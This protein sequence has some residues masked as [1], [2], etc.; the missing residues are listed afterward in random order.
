MC[1]ICGQVRTGGASET[2][3]ARMVQAL[4]HRGPDDRGIHRSGPAVL[5]H[6][7]LSIID[8]S[9]GHQPVPNET[10]DCWVVFN[11]EIYNYRE[12]RQDLI[13]RGHR[14]ATHSDTEVLVHAYEEWGD[15]CVDRLRG[16]FAFA[17]WDEVRGRL[18]AARDHLGQKPFYYVEGAGEFSFASEIKA[19]LA[20][21]PALAELDPAAL[22][23]YLTLRIVMPPHSMFRRIRKLPPAHKLVFDMERGL[24]ISRYWD[25]EYEPK[26]A[27]SDA[28]LTDRLEQEIVES[29]KAHVVSDVPIGAFLSGGLDSTLVVALLAKFVLDEPIQTFSGSLAYKDFDEAPHARAV[30]ERYGTLHHEQA[31]EP[32]LRLLPMLVAQMDEPSDPLAVCSYLIAGMA[33]QHV[34][35]VLG[36]DGGDELFGGYDR[37]YGNRFAS[38]YALLPRAIREHVT[39]ALL[40]RTSDGGWYKSRGNQLRWLHQ[41]SFL[42]GGARYAASLGSFY[43]LGSEGDDLFTPEF[44]NQLSGADPTAPIIAAYESARAEHP[45]D[46]MLHVDSQLRM[47]DHPVMILDRMTMAHGLEARSPFLDHK[48]AEFA[49]RLP[50]RLKVRGWSLRRVQRMLAKRHLPPSLLQRPKQGF[51]VALPYMLRDEYSLFFRLFLENATLVSDGILQKAAVD[52]LLTAHRAGRMDHGNRLWLLLNAEIWYRIFLGGVA[53]ADLT[54]VVEQAHERQVEAA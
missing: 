27:G 22:Q 6:T 32:S 34:K 7:R 28:A 3:V 41:L 52:R 5:G 43:F 42:E 21:D 46:R 37:Y 47:P 36:G 30:A 29:L 48:L 1:G 39:G 13:G 16:M 31:I 8:L 23:Q 35:V 50:M 38:V 49:A 53:H 4:H 40:R 11:G 9:Q 45:I 20:L 15:A 2:G 18:F 12:L 10:G 54:A 17:I 25:L 33:R 19:L 26:L 14:F 24:R 44:R 51:S